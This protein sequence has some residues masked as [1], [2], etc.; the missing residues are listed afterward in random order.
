MADDGQLSQARQELSTVAEFLTHTAETHRS[1]PVLRYFHFRRH[2]YALP[3][4]L[5][6]SLSS[7]T[8]A[9][10]ALA[11]DRYRGLIRSSAVYQ[12]AAAGAEALQELAPQVK[13]SPPADDQVAEWRRRFRAD[14]EILRTAGVDVVADLHQGADEY[15]ALRALWDA[16]L[17]ALSAQML[18][19]WDDIEVV[20]Q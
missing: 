12:L 20:R 2:R 8:L 4:L 11:P 18:Y 9:Q 17:R 19:E 3:R 6:L 10:A 15:V 13:P 5:L 1:Y 14:V 16:P 7:A